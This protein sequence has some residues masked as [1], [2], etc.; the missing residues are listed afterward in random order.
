MT[1]EVSAEGRALIQQF[2]GLSLTAYLLLMTDNYPRYDSVTPTS[3]LA[4]GD[5]DRQ[6][7]RRA[8]MPPT[9]GGNPLPPPTGPPAG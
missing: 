4:P 6:D 8:V 5:L 9:G 1:R 2:E 3:A 7:G